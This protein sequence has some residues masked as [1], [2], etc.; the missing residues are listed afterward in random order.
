MN[1]QMENNVPAYDKNKRS[2]HAD[3]RDILF[4]LLT[5][6]CT[7]LCVALGLWGGFQAGWT[8]AFLVTWIAATVYLSA[9]KNKPGRF[10][11]VCGILSLLM[12]AIFPA[13]SNYSVRFLSVP[14]MLLL[15]LIWFAALCGK[16]VPQGDTGLFRHWMRCIGNAFGDLFPTMRALFSQESEKKKRSL[17]CLAGVLCALPVLC[18][19]IPLLARSDAAFEGLVHGLFADIGSTVGQFIVTLILVPFT[20]TL[21]FS[22][23]RREPEPYADKA[24]K[25]L[26]TLLLTAFFS[27]LSLCYLAYLFSQMAY[28]FSAFSG[29][30]PEGYAFSYAE[31]ARRGFFELCGIAA[32]NLGLI[33]LMILLSRKKDGK[34]PVVLRVFGTFIGLFT[35]L[36]I[37]TAISKMVLYIRNYGMTVDRLSTSAFMAFL[38]VVFLAV[39]CRCFSEKIK[40]LQTAIITAGVILLVLG[41]GNVNA[42]C[43]R[44]N[45]EAYRSG[46]LPEIDMYYLAELGEEG[47]PYLLRLTEKDVPG[48]AVRNNAMTYASTMSYAFDTLYFSEYIEMPNGVD[49]YYQPTEKMYP[50]LSQYSIPRAEAY[51]ELDA[52]LEKKPN[53]FKDAAV[54]PPSEDYLY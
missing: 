18:I 37:A 5:V 24:S 41:V 22:L 28:F 26:D 19:V 16:H 54:I 49:S 30:L 36:L 35:L 44:Y 2:F 6:V 21:L 11:W 52:F 9:G 53:F 23:R 38:A 8:A 34:L 31:Y 7:F 3:G 40:V 12:A 25:G 4:A 27:A 47:V 15:A 17:L 1:E 39:I 14:V 13:T 10:A 29:L 45:Y 43:A 48:P 42:V 20:V 51:R 33:F 46:A 32:I 50:K